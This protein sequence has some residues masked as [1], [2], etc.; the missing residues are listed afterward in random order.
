[1][2]DERGRAVPRRQLLAAVATAGVAVGLAGCS[3]GGDGTTDPTSTGASGTDPTGGDGSTS[4]GGEAASTGDGGAASTA[5]DRTSTT[6]EGTTGEAEGVSTAVSL[7]VRNSQSNVGEFQ[8][9][10]TAF[11]G[12]ELVSTDGNTVRRAAETAELDLT[13]IGPGGTVDLFETGIPAGEYEEARLYMP[14]QEA[15]LADGSEPEFERTVPASREIRG[16]DPVTIESGGSVDLRLT[17]ALIRIAGDGPW[18]YTL[19]W[20]VR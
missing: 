13:E 4:A 5:T 19:G 14:I 17:V 18:T 9:L 2:T 12:V 8:T 3:S 1:M 20:G 10:R 15:T 16:G 7:T 11:E 6:G